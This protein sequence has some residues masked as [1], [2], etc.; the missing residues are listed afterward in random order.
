MARKTKKAPV[1]PV[2]R[3]TTPPPPEPLR[4]HQALQKAYRD[5]LEAMTELADEYGADETPDRLVQRAQAILGAPTLEAAAAIARRTWDG[6]LVHVL[7]Q[8]AKGHIPGKRSDLAFERNIKK[9]LSL[10]DMLEGRGLRDQAAGQRE[11]AARLRDE[12]DDFK[13]G[14]GRAV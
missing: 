13:A 11:R 3:P 5:A 6:M 14:A 1:A 7:S 10:A 12:W 4:D 9:A 2:A 8:W